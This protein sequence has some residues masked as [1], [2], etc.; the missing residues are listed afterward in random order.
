MRINCSSTWRRVDDHDRNSRHPVGPINNT[1]NH[2]PDLSITNIHS[3]WVPCNASATCFPSGRQHCKSFWSSGSSRCEWVAQWTLTVSTR[4]GS[5]VAATRRRTASGM[6]AY[7]C[8]RSNHLG[9]I[10]KS[11]LHSPSTKHSAAKFCNKSV[12]SQWDTQSE[13]PRHISA[14]LHS[15]PRTRTPT[16]ADTRHQRWPLQENRDGDHTMELV[17]W[18]FPPILN[19]FRVGTRIIWRGLRFDTL[20]LQKSCSFGLFDQ[21]LI[22]WAWLIILTSL[23][24]QIKISKIIRSQSILPQIF[25]GSEVLQTLAIGQ[26][27][28]GGLPCTPSFGHSPTRLG[29]K[30]QFVVAILANICS[31]GTNTTQQS[32]RVKSE[33]IAYKQSL[34]K[35]SLGDRV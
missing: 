5:K 34:C 18:C 3:N 11:S 12:Q 33:V 8:A 17:W 22:M 4:V 30:L 29:C 21:M 15:L 26:W 7:I 9:L 19:N 13:N 35:V 1:A 20:T 31:N 28:I 14:F 10:T 2:T 24:P 16:S 23:T 25:A 32:A 27:R 6:R